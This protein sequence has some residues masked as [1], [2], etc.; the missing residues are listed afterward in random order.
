MNVDNQ[1][2]TDED[3]LEIIEFMLEHDEL[4]EIMSK[5]FE[6]PIGPMKINMQAAAYQLLKK[7]F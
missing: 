7:R 1:I 6:K 2:S 3:L 5:H 4:I